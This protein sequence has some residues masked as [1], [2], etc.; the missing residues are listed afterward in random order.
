M[1]FRSKCFSKK[2]YLSTTRKW[3]KNCVNIS[4]WTFSLFDSCIWKF[5][6]QD[7]LHFHM[8]TRDWVP[9]WCSGQVLALRSPRPW[10]SECH[11]SWMLQSQ[12]H[13]NCEDHWPSILHRGPVYIS[14]YPLLAAWALISLGKNLLS[15]LGSHGSCGSFSGGIR[16]SRHLIPNFWARR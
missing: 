11:S 13:L 5:L 12:P 1:I 14:Y 15:P 6:T 2:H 9:C 8:K 7:C 16:L 10:N 4:Q 3:I